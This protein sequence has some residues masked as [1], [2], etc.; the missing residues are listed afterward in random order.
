M[1]QR[2]E[3][4]LEPGMIGPVK[5]CNRMLKTANGTSFMEPDQTVG[6]RMIAWYERLARG[7][8]GFI[9]I[10]SS[11]VEYPLGVHHVHYL[12]DGSYQGVQLHF[13]DDKYIPGF[14]RLTEA[15]HKHGCPISIQLLHSGPWDP[16]GLLPRDLK[17]RDVKCP[18]TLTEEELPGPDF[19]PCRAMTKQEIEDE[20]DIWAAA[21]ERAHRAGFDACEINHGTCHQ[22]NT[23]LSRVWN[24]RDDEYGS[25]NYENRTRFVRNIVTEAKRRCGPGFAVHVLMNAVEY[26]HPLATTLEEGAEMAKLIA[27]VADGLNVRSERY[28][29][30]Q[31]LQQ[32]D[33]I[34]YPEPPVDLPADLDWSRRG[35]GA[36]VPLVEAV[37][38]KGVTT[39]VWSACRL[40]PEMGEEYLR[41]GSIDFVAM[42]RRLLAD[43]ELPNKVKEGRLEDIR[44]CTGCLH[45]FDV[46]NKNKVLE[47]RV[48]ATLGREIVPE[49][50]LRPASPKKKVLVVGG[51][52]AGMEAARVAAQRGHEVVLYEKESGLGG[53]VP[54]AAVVKD[55]ETEE[56]TDLTHYFETQLK[57]E[58]VVVHLKKGVTPDV[59]RSERPDVLVLAGGAA[60]T[61]FD[62]PGADSRRFIKT[63][64]LH[65]RLKL[66]LKFLS[67]AALERLTRVWMP[68][69]RSV[70]IMGGELHG[71]ELGEFLAKRGRR[72]VIVHDGPASELGAGMTTDDL[73]NLWPWFKLKHVPLWTDAQYREIVDRGLKI[74]VSDKRVFLLEG[75]SVMTTQDWGPNT[76]LIQELEGLVSET[77][78]IG[79][80]REPGWI[81]DAIREGALAGYSI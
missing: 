27:D 15:V 40:D 8:V 39:P 41:K 78:V 80:C 60:H 65:S 52:P 77:H 30:R 36:T 6:P 37:K 19:L 4:I 24:R 29:H 76:K 79:S 70:V 21:A 34:L 50:Q 72:V 11:G 28:G 47:C 32:P 7:G 10:E 73:E 12:P 53:L 67:A 38:A 35:R 62:L 64:K 54:V 5:T 69:A 1:S 16:T 57:K 49:Y 23:F 51:G 26:N 48:N 42:T 3:K 22:G 43:P 55:L 33:R 9:V 31:G 75:K 13:D 59:V 74:Q 71:C 20:I 81:V 46:R 61:E 68:L 18:S 17:I 25:Q 2:L 56:L 14:Q 66:A 45:C 58:G 63:E 44:P